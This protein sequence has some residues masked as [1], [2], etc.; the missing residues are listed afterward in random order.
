[1]F[2]S[3]SHGLWWTCIVDPVWLVGQFVQHSLQVREVVE[4]WKNKLLDL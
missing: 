3:R 2:V 4:D 1:V